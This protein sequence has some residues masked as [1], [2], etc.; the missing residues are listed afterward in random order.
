MCAREQK[1]NV[2]TC[3]F[4]KNKNLK[5]SF[6]TVPC[7]ILMIIE[8]KKNLKSKRDFLLEKRT[9]VIVFKNISQ[10]KKKV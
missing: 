5:M 6:S 2:Y 7:I 1:E 3:L 8:K 9:N 4:E 10:R